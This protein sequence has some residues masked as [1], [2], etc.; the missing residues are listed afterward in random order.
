MVCTSE[1]SGSPTRRDAVSVHPR[2]TGNAQGKSVPR[3]RPIP[4]QG[5]H[6]REES[7]LKR[8]TTVFPDGHE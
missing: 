1:F 3:R 4:W 5:G 6:A 8:D 2:V 7:P